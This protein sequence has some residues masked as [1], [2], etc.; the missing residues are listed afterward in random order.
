MLMAL[1]LSHPGDCLLDLRQVGGCGGC[2]NLL[3]KPSPL[4]RQGVSMEMKI[5]VQANAG[6]SVGHV[7]ARAVVLLSFLLLGAHG[8][9][10]AQATN[11]QDNSALHPPAG[12]NVAIVEFSDPEC[13]ACARV[14]PLLQGAAARYK[15]AW[16]RHDLIMQSHPW[17]LNA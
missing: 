9:M 6:R 17:S 1:R 5:K 2:V 14:N 12:A 16:I 11:V 4:R 10:H 3:S 7:A 8:R 15:I 13:P